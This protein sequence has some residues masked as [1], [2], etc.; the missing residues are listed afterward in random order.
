LKRKKNQKF[1]TK[2]LRTAETCSDGEIQAE[3]KS[4]DT[5]LDQTGGGGRAGG[6]EREKE[7][8]SVLLF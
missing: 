5:H 6:R 4:K 7:K 2:N 8:I 3:T 1:E